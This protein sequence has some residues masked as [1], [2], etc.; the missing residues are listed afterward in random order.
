MDLLG[1]ADPR[2]IGGYPL[3]ARLGAGG[4]GQVY[5]ARTPAGRPLA[6][7][8][9]RGEFGGDPS[10]GERFAREIRSADLVRSP[11][12]AVVVDYSPAGSG[13][14]WLATEYVP[15]PSLAEWVAAAG[16]LPRDAL[17]ALAAELCE[18][19]QAVH[20]AG[21]AHRDVKP[22]NVLLP[23]TRPLLIDFGIARAA[24]D[25]RHTR[26]GGVIGSPGYMAPEQATAG[27]SAEPGD[28]FALG[29]VLV[30]A[31][32]GRG[33]FHRPGE[34]ASTPSLL[35]RVVHEEPDLG[36]VP[37]EL[38]PF[39]RA[40]LAKDPAARPTARDAAALLPAAGAGAPAGDRTAAAWA[41]HLP[42]GL[43]AEIA[44]REAAAAAALGR[45][46]HARAGAA[47][48]VPTA[49]PAAAAGAVASA[50]A[51]S[52]GR[53]GA[54]PA[55]TASAGAGH[56]DGA[57]LA[58]TGHA[59]GAEHVGSTGHAGGTGLAGG[60]GPVGS[61]GR[62]GTGHAGGT[63]LGPSPYSPGV[64]AQAGPGT[65]AT[66]PYGHPAYGRQTAPQTAPAP[67][68]GPAGPAASA[69]WGGVPRP[70][71]TGPGQPRRGRGVLVAAVVAGVVVLALLGLLIRNLADSSKGDDANGSGG[72]SGGPTT[73]ST[74][75]AA[76]ST[77]ASTGASTGAVD[78][79]ALP[80]SWVGTWSGTGP[81]DPSGSGG[82]PRTDSFKVT[83]TLT[84]GR[85]GD[86]VGRQVSHVHDMDSSADAGCT[87]TLKLASMDGDTARF[88][89]V[90]AR[91]TDSSAGGVCL[92]GNTYEVTMV[93]GALH[94]GA[95]SQAAGSP[96]TF[97][98]V[99]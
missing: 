35:Y 55:G 67:G 85:R 30:Y 40:C 78:P 77:S 94:L 65:A 69:G 42:P 2:S 79:D 75:S 3:F 22:S 53:P 87:E 97:T 54:A 83:L 52:D 84:G 59:G 28:V 33:P 46:P 21:L 60:S 98:K 56:A 26:A 88:T 41:A 19:L 96:A 8:T 45:D 10:F 70:V 32:A 18:G 17:T 66:T 64:A 71:P 44:S 16:P 62:P 27:V 99:T 36:G 6:L 57:G 34:E 68:V 9:L 7:K 11:W 47:G 50:R 73:S 74:A 25:S 13:P 31:A 91:H 92:P 63:A 38:L 37:E 23:R 15:A 86:V 1:E 48:T 89:A 93:D 95:G 58:G 5:L 49:S 14:Q 20:R 61:A 81:G 72:G 90:T 43:D 12:T 76:T 29:A 51:L 24:E 82:G 4:M 39:V 80:A